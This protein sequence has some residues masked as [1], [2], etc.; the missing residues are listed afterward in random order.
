[1]PTPC[2]LRGILAIGEAPGADEDMAG[3]G[4]VGRA[5]KTL[6]LLF[7]E[8]GISRSEYGRANVCRCRPVDDSGQNRKPTPDEIASCLPKLSDF[9]LACQPLVILCV[10]ATPARHFYPQKNLFDMILSGA[11][12]FL[13]GVWGNPPIL[14]GMTEK[15]HVVPMPHTSPLAFNRTAPDGRKWSAIARQQIALAVEIARTSS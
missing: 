1:M 5:G 6:D 10:G 15:V 12:E 8:V 9:I 11:R 2:K 7:S 3:E 4:F 14:Y 13:P